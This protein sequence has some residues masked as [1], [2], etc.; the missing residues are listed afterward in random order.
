MFFKKNSFFRRKWPN[1][2]EWGCLFSVLNKKEKA[3]FLFSFLVFLLSLIFIASNFYIKNT[4]IEP[5]EGGLYR[6]GVIGQPRFINPI[7]IESDIDR[8]LVELI[9]SGLMKYDSNLNIVPDLVEKYEI[10]EDG[11]VYKF[12]LKEDLSWQDGHSLTADDVIFTIKAIQNSDYKSYSRANWLGVDVE[13]IDDLTIKFRLRRSYSSFLENL[14][15]KIM[16]KHIWENIPPANF[17][18]SAYHLNPIGSGPYKLKEIKRNKEEVIESFSLIKNP[19][20]SGKEPKI[21]EIKF[22]FFENEKNL[23]HAASRRK[24]DGLHIG[25]S[26]AYK[27]DPTSIKNWQIFRI[28]F[29]RYFSLFFNTELVKEKEIRKALSYA[30]DKEFIV[31]N[32][33]YGDIT[34]Q[35]VKSP[36]LPNIYG[37]ESPSLNYDY[38]KEKAG[39]ILDNLGFKMSENGKREKIT[40]KDPSF[41]FKSELKTGSSGKEVEELQRCLAKFE[42][43]YPEKEITAYFGE[44]TKSA[45]ISFQK[46]YIIEESGIVNKETREKLNEICFSNGETIFP[47]EINLKIINHPELRKV[48]EAI[49]ENWE[50]IGIIVNI[51]EIP[52]NERDNLIKSRDYEAIVLGKVLGAIPDPFPFWHSSQKAD[53]G[54]NLSLYENEKADKL[55]EEIRETTS[56]EEWVKKMSELQEIIIEDAPAIFLYSPDY[57]YAVSQKVKGINVEKIAD[58]SKRFL[59]IEEWFIKTKRVWK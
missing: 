51:E 15:V 57:I 27:Y 10:E 2:S 48:S 13:K 40:K 37:L 41:Q 31:K 34:D 9:F 49:K 21:Q 50:E 54:Y 30:T 59:Q 28:I 36:F 35:I 52:I 47:L 45:I 17:F 23:I 26:D 55:L 44:K 42:D 58:P 1:R 14:T 20:Y 6:E 19:Y 11:R 3:M 16:P 24:I 43:I 12:Y 33:L 39:E 8:D 25:F 7:Y 46:K 56:K 53:P 29:P 32:V 22:L 38:N 4:T 18:S 5:S